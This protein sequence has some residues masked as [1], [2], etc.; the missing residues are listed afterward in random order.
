[1][2]GKGMGGRH[3][4]DSRPSPQVS[5]SFAQILHFPQAYMCSSVHAEYPSH[6]GKFE[7]LRSILTSA[8]ASKEINAL[9]S[10]NF[11]SG[12]VYLE[13]REG[14]IFDLLQIDR[15]MVGLSVHEG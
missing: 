1:M 12:G 13:V 6:T 15:D 3:F 9:P 5:D 11:S 8:I 10:D 2:N 14:L 4:H 7:P